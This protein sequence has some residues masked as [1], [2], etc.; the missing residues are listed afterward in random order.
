[1][2]SALIIVQAVVFVFSGRHSEVKT[3][4]EGTAVKEDGTKKSSPP[5]RS[6]SLPAASQLLHMTLSLLTPRTPRLKEEELKL[7]KMPRN[8][9]K[10]ASG[11]AGGGG[12]SGGPDG[13]VNLEPSDEEESQEADVIVL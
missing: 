5:P 6:P 8:S 3:R 12:N 10:R 2:A 4:E 9:L 7:E 13:K 11:A 1:M